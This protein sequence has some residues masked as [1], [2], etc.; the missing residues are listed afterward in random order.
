MN[1]EI[2]AAAA[3]WPRWRKALF[4]FT[5]LYLLLLLAP[6][7]WP[8]SVPG[9]SLITTYYSGAEHWLV[10]LGNRHLLHVKDALVDPNGSGDTSYVY[11]Q[12]GVLALLA[13]AGTLLW[14][15]LDRRRRS[16]N[17]ASYWLLVLVRY[18]VALAAFSY[19]LLKVFALQMMFPDQSALATPLG[20]LL[21][22]RLAWYFIG[23]SHSYQVFSGLME[24]LAGLLL[25]W[26]RTAMLGA[27]VA[28]GVF[29]NVMMLNLCYDI[30]VKLYSAQLFLLSLLLLL[31]DLG[32]L[33]RF[34]VLHQ[35]V[36]APLP[37]PALP[38][39]HWRVA[40]LTL[41]VVFIGLFA[42]MPLVQMFAYGA[43]GAAAR[44]QRLTTGVFRVAQFDG[45]AGDSL[46]WRN[47]IFD[48]SPMGSIATADTAFQRRYGRGYF[49]YQLDSAAH[50]LIL[51]KTRADTSTLGRLHY[52]W[53]D[54]NHL[55][56]RGRLRHDSVR[57]AL[58]RQPRHF[59]LAERQFHWLSE[60]NR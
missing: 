4:R 32:R 56:L 36:A 50:V 45:P 40:R 12:L 8:G 14:G 7:T 31:P 21:P 29:L 19:G 59:Q 22:M 44:H 13:L 28:T 26:R 24:L 53:A 48:S 10:E 57:V 5:C 58:V 25:L 6:W 47:V 46:R 35:P 38:T 27:L 60:A 49:S 2:S 43:E 17:L 55:E 52:A 23:Y 15:L 34:F 54:S 42:L 33:F 3:P 37:P 51:R 41:K 30:P 11:A 1:P 18:F 16:Y 9:V 39:W 20:D